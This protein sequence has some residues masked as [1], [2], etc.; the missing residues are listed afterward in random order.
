M[1]SNYVGPHI[2]DINDKRLFGI[3]WL[4]TSNYKKGFVLFW[5]LILFI[6]LMSSISGVP[7]LPPTK[8]AFH[9]SLSHDNMIALNNAILKFDSV[10]LDTANAYKNMTGVFT[11]PETGIYVITWT[12]SVHPHAGAYTF[13]LI[14]GKS[15]GNSYSDSDGGGDND[16]DTGIIVLKLMQGDDVHVEFGPRLSF[17]QLDTLFGQTTFSAWKL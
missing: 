10:L 1:P 11:V 6:N 2:Y 5:E 17:G 13:I 14:N 15:Y 8:I 9:A 16:S 4:R 7:E 12:T 3:V